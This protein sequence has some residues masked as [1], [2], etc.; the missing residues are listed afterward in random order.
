MRK[1]LVG[2]IVLIVSLVFIGIIL[3]PVIHPYI[4]LQRIDKEISDYPNTIVIVDTNN[5]LPKN[6]TASVLDRLYSPWH[7]VIFR[8][9]DYDTV[10]ALILYAELKPVRMIIVTHGMRTIPKGLLAITSITPPDEKERLMH[11]FDINSRIAVIGLDYS[12]NL[13]LS[14]VL[15]RA[16]KL[17]EYSHIY[18]VSCPIPGMES[19]LA[20]LLSKNTEVCYTVISP[21]SKMLWPLVEEYLEYIST[22]KTPIYTNF[23]CISR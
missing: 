23:T 6:I 12:H 13:W 19:R 18:L 1:E 4:I 7:F 11:L 21:T 14:L 9:V 22:G 3:Y 15:D 17:H 16:G 2:G 5:L 8:G 10:K 20:P